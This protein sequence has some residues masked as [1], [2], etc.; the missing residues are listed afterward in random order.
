MV[1]GYNEDEWEPVYRVYAGQGWDAHDDYTS[2]QRAATDGDHDDGQFRS[3]KL[4]QWHYSKIH[5]VSTPN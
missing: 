4:D 3:W 5:K 2:M 1:P